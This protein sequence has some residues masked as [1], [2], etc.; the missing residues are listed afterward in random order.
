MSWIK[1]LFGPKKR[2]EY[3][4]WPG[5][6]KQNEVN[7]DKEKMITYTVTETCLGNPI[8]IQVRTEQYCVYCK[9]F[10]DPEFHDPA[11]PG[12]GGYCCRGN[13]G[14]GFKDSCKDWEPN[15]KV[16][17]WLSKG[18]MQNNREGCPRSPWY[19]VFDDG[20]DGAEGAG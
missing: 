8:S 9:H 20:P 14:I 3:D 17:Y 11:F 19:K 1:N 12:G 7:P 10:S 18:Y 5:I 4:I 6:V 13:G 2:N 16:R 15:T